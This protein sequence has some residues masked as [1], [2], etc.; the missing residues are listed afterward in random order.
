ME[1]A[2]RLAC[3]ADIIP[4]VLD[5]EGV[6][7]DEGWAKRLATAEQR[8][9]LEAMQSTCSHPDCTV[10]IDDCRIHHRNRGTRAVRPTSRTSWASAAAGQAL[11]VARW[12]SIQDSS[13]GP[14]S[15]LEIR[16]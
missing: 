4:V 13:A 6:V 9:A 12:V 3:E 1:T 14:L 8:I 10:T 11:T 5:G 2:R 16:A 15:K 7:L